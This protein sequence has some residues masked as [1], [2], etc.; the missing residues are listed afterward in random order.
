M[1][2]S[3][4]LLSSSITLT[5]LLCFFAFFH[6]IHFI[7]RQ[8]IFIRGQLSKSI[9]SCIFLCWNLQIQVGLMDDRGQAVRGSRSS[10]Q[11]DILSDSCSPSDMVNCNFVPKDFVLC[12]PGETVANFLSSGDKPF[13]LNEYKE[14]AMLDFCKLVSTWEKVTQVCQITHYTKLQLSSKWS[15]HNSEL[16]GCTV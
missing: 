5:I 4:A 6:N 15:T 14:I 12:L 9:V 16:D 11:S 2:H 3:C 10:A 8:L 1:G 13:S 7:I